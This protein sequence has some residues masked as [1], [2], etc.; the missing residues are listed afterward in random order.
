M[1]ESFTCSICGKL[2][3]IHLTQIINNK[4]HKIDLC[5]QCAQQKAI[6]D[7]EVISFMEMVTKPFVDKKTARDLELTLKCKVCKC[8][9]KD[10]KKEG[11]LGCEHCYEYL[12]P[13][14]DGLLEKLYKN[15]K[16]LGKCPMRGS[17]GQSKKRQLDLLD[18]QIAEAI[19]HEQY[20]EAAL[21]RDQKKALESA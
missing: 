8:E 7:A 2:A 5:E 18:H 3:T 4:V 11:R 16:H 15:K 17:K 12:K 20:E 6:M 13:A 9:L 10:F 21:F 14:L 19:K 1:V